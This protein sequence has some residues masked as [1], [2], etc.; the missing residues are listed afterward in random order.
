M[1]TPP[2]HEVTRLLLDWRGGDRAALDRLVP[3]VQGELRRL[4]HAYMRRERDGHTLQTS[5]L[6]N[7]AYL[8]LIDDA[9]VDWQSR[10]HFFGVAAQAMRRVLVDHARSRGALKRGAGARAV[11]LEAVGAMLVDERAGELVALDDALDELARVDP[12]KVRVIELR[13]FGG[14]TGEETA[15][16]LGLSSATVQ[17]EWHVAKM[18]LLRELAKASDNGG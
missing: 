13:F 1:S 14:L 10:A 5:A 18:W 15:E 9:D 17:R 8:R 3:I 4:A 6:I 12:R 7:E 2:Q 11:D 16:A